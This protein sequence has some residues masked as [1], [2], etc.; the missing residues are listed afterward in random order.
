MKN[1]FVKR[2]NRFFMI[3]VE[4][5]TYKEKPL[6]YYY[7]SNLEIQQN[8]QAYESVTAANVHGHCF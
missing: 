2:Q 1:G 8:R 6:P 5:I 7:Q 4:K 3:Y